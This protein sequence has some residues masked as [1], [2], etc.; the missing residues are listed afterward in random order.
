MHNRF[1]L[2]LLAALWSVAACE[3]KET[4]PPPADPA[5]TVTLHNAFNLVEAQ[6]AAFVSD[7]DGRIRAFR[8][9]PGTDTARLT[10][11]EARA[12]EQ[13]DCTVVKIVPLLAPGTGI[14]D[15]TVTLTTYTGLTTSTD[16]YLRDPSNVQAT[17]LFLTLTGASTLDSIVVPDGITFALPQPDNNFRGEYRVF[18]TGR[19]W[20]R[21]KVN[22]EPTW[23]Y[24][25][26]DNVNTPTLDIQR[27]V[28]TLPELPPSSTAIALPFF[29]DWTY[30]LD[31]VINLNQGHFLSLS[32]LV[33]IPGG[34]VPFFDAIAVFEPPTLPGNGYR[35]RLSG[36]DPA[37]GGYGYVCDRF[38]QQ[39]PASMSAPV[40]DIAPTNLAGN[41]LVGVVSSGPVDVLALTRFGTPNLT[42]EV[43]AQPTSTGLLAYRLPDV[44]AG[45]GDL[46]PA[47]KSYS[48][49][50]RVRVRAEHYEQ[51]GSY[52]EAIAPRL[53]Q[54]DPLW[55]MKA[56]YTARL[57]VF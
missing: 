24:L 3:K 27:D 49:D 50:G 30:H 11:P 28:A 34:V 43:L 14:R 23:R 47:L 5:F 51:F 41:R 4:P 9:L 53:M 6:Y 40:F 48:F 17:D 19:F 20:C 32:P 54:N 12:G 8:W 36:F 35:L 46:F 33:P 2:L 22:G 39:L 18:H 13:F 55:Q 29:A 7:E 45:L 1:L 57:R 26:F 37:P 42:W 44:P 52:R 56:G 16:I 38:F 31:R 15:T 25:V 21:I 10:V